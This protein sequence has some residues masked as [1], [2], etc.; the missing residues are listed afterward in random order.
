[1][2][3]LVL[4]I[5]LGF[6]SLSFGSPKSEGI[7][8]ELKNKV[9]VD[10]STIRLNMYEEDYVIVDF[11][12]VDGMINI[13]EIGGTQNALVDLMVSELQTFVV[14]SGYDKDKLYLYEF[15]LEKV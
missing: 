9:S 1:M 14:E 12:I 11:T 15:T 2:K 10:L 5:V 7:G 3:K 8:A 6:S 13:V 4:V